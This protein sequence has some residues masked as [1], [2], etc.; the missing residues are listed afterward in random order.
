[1]AREK[2]KMEAA[3]GWHKE[4]TAR[5]RQI[6]K[7]IFVTHSLGESNM[8]PGWEPPGLSTC[9]KTKRILAVVWT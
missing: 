2:E 8:Q 9:T 4:K 5:K 6:N 3:P 7:H 1:M